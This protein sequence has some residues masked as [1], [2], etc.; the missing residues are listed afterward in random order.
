MTRPAALETAWEKGIYRITIDCF[1]CGRQLNLT[2]SK[3]ETVQRY[4]RHVTCP[5]CG[6][7]LGRV[8]P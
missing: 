8:E 2:I 1:N 6:C 3:G 5:N 4:L 7:K